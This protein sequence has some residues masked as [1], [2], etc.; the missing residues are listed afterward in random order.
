LALQR[1]E[2]MD[3]RKEL[4]KHREVFELQSF[5]STFFQMLKLHNDIL[6]SIDVQTT[7]KDGSIQVNSTGRDCFRNYSNTLRRYYKTETKNNKIQNKI[8]E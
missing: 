5:E 6:N 4:S 7:D 2:L 1:A 8:T 3:T